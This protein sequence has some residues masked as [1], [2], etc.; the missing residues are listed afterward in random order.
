MVLSL[1]LLLVSFCFDVLA[2]LSAPC[3]RGVFARGSGDVL[4]R[5]LESLCRAWRG[6]AGFGAVLRWQ[7][8]FVGA[9]Q[10]ANLVGTQ[11]ACGRRQC[12]Q[13]RGIAVPLGSA[14][15]APAEHGSALQGCVLLLWERCK[16]RTS[17]VLMWR[18]GGASAASFAD[19]RAF[20]HCLEGSC[21]AWLGTTGLR[22]VLRCLRAASVG[23]GQAANLAGAHVWRAGGASAASFTGSPCLW[24]LSGGFL[25]SAARHYIGCGLLRGFGASVRRCFVRRDYPSA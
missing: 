6:I 19:R 13:L 7:R 16:S 12:G 21:R 17:Q 15:K 3:G 24:A 8:A 5:C 11:A 14:W 1:C 2:R 25:P 20:G 10:A 4:W 23:A 9:A 18:A 22:A